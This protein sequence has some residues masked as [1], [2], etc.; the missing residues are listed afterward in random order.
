MTQTLLF[1]NNVPKFFGSEA[2]FTAAYLINRLSSVN[3]NFKSPLEIFY[4]QKIN[5]DHL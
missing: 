5:I 4:G 3:L 2:V 1:Q